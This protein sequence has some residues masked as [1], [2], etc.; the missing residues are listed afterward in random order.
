[1][2]QQSKY[3]KAD[4]L[5]PS[6]IFSKSQTALH[7]LWALLIIFSSFNLQTYL[8]ILEPMIKGYN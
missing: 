3:K 8:E 4:I 1:M 5:G 6:L 7:V 2:D